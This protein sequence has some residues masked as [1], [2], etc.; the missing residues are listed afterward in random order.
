[1]IN[2][3]FI[4]IEGQFYDKIDNLSGVPTPGKKI[5]VNN[6]LLSIRCS[7]RYIDE[8]KD[9]RNLYIDLISNKK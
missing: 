3:T 7:V 1:M 5:K 2:N 9:I 8:E 4:C 6:D